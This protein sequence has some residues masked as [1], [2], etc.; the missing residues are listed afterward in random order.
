MTMMGERMQSIISDAVKFGVF[1]AVGQTDQKSAGKA[2]MQGYLARDPKVSFHFYPTARAKAEFPDVDGVDAQKIAV[3]RDPSTINSDDRLRDLG[4]STVL[5]LMEA[6]QRVGQHQPIEV[7]GKETDA[8]VK[9]GAGGHRLEACRR[10]GIKVLCFHYDGDDLDRQL[11]EIDENLIREDL[12]PVDRALFLARRKEIYLIKHPETAREATL[13]KGEVAPSRR[14]GETAKRFTAATADAT[15]QKERTI[16]RDVERGEKISEKALR[17]LRGTSHDKGTLLDRLK[18]M[19]SAE[20][21]ENF[22]VELIASDK[23]TT[24]KSKKIRTALQAD[25]RQA[26]LRMVNL[27]SEHGH[28]AGVDMP[29]SAYPV[30]YAD[31]P[32]QQEQWSEV[33]GQDKGLKYPAMPLDDIKALCA[34]DKSPFTRDAVLLLWVTA[35]RLPDGIAV[36]QSWGFEYATCM[37]W[38]KQHIGMGRWVRDR[39]EILLIGKRGTISLAPLMGTQPESLYS[40]AKT[41]HSRKPV[42]FAEQIERLWPELRKIELFQ[43]KDSLG[44]DDVRLNGNWEFWGN[45]AGTP[46]GG[47][48]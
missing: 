3:L 40:E 26:R 32:W 12:S 42:W 22:V 33:T 34:G 11:C 47:A 2:H 16:Q 48:E 10:L 27:I 4:E 38:D 37:I 36:L 6:F 31:P 9:L 1:V 5:A 29:L 28:K 17:M 35:N 15:A 13:K 39:H 18:R 25:N 14:V 19:D 8:T 24:A 43:R 44:P 7:F 20:A 23:A 45:Q 46:E 21:Q 30:G 41:E